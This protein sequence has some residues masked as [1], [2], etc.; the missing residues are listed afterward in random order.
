MC[1]V[2]VGGSG[3][4]SRRGGP[5][6]SWSLHPMRP[7]PP[8]ADCAP[9]TGDPERCWA[10]PGTRPSRRGDARR[11]LWRCAPRSTAALGGRVGAVGV[12]PALSPGSEKGG[13]GE[14]PPLQASMSPRN[15]PGRRAGEA[16]GP[17]GVAPEPAE[18]VGSS[19]GRVWFQFPSVSPLLSGEGPGHRHA[20]HMQMNVFA[21]PS[22]TPNPGDL[23]TLLAT[24]PKRKPLLLSAR[25]R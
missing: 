21:F 8:G 13:L 20:K 24:C 18:D 23:L 11:G 10:L 9:P 6:S 25:P 14:V 15:G 1:D 12:R 7:S 22:R 3:G 4:G 2:R 16:R 19:L 5:A 17:R